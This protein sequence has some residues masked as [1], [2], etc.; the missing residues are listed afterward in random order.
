M[1]VITCPNCTHQAPERIPQDACLHIFVCPG[2]GTRLTPRTGDCCVFC[3]Y[4]DRLCPT[5]G[6]VQ[7][8]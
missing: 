8:T 3:S 5:R 7:T 2:C 6:D 1:G 4:G